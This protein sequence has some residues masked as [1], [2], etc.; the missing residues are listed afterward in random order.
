MPTPPAEVNDPKNARPA[1]LPIIALP[2]FTVAAIFTG[3]GSRQAAAVQTNPGLRHAA[4]TASRGVG[5]RR[6][7]AD[8]GGGQWSSQW[9]SWAA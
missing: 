2:L 5:D 8:P 3:D 7:S 9:P 1:L 6:P 4:R